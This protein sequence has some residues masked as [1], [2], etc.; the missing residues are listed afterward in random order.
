MIFPSLEDCIKSFSN[1]P[2]M[3]S[4]YENILDIKIEENDLDYEHDRD[5][6]LSLSYDT[7][8]ETYDWLKEDISSND[9]IYRVINHDINIDEIQK[10]SEV[11]LHWT[12]SYQTAK[13]IAEDKLFYDNPI[14]I[15]GKIDPSCVDFEYSFMLRNAYPDEWELYLEDCPISIKKITKL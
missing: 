6:A 11:G 12:N 2:D 9:S 1:H 4:Y 7:F 8:K 10:T 15:E 3:Y 5:K 13:Y 14:I